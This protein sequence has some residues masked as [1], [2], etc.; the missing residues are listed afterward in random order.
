MRHT[1]KNNTGFTLVELIATLTLLTLLVLVAM[2]IMDR[3][4]S[5]STAKIDDAEIEMIET[6]ASAADNNGV[7]H[8]EPNLDQYKIRTLVE[9]GHLALDDEALYD[10]WVVGNDSGGY[11]YLGEREETPASDFTY[12]TVSSSYIGR[13]EETTS[14]PESLAGIAI[15]GY[16]GSSKE[17]VIPEEIDGQP[18][19]L[20]TTDALRENGFTAVYLPETVG[21]IEAGAFHSNNIS[22]FYTPDSIYRIDSNAFRSN[23]MTEAELPAN[24]EVM[25]HSTYRDNPIKHVDMGHMERLKSTAAYIF[26][27]TELES[28]VLPPNFEKVGDGMFQ[29]LNLSSI[30]LPDTLKEIGNNAFYGNDIKRVSIPDGVEEIGQHAFSHNGMRAV[31]LSPNTVTYGAYAFFTNELTEVE[32]PGNK[33]RELGGF[34]FHSNNLREVVLPEGLTTMGNQVF[35]NNSI[36]YVKLP[37]TLQSMGGY[38]FYTNNLGRVDGYRSGIDEGVAVWGGNPDVRFD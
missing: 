8:D 34:A 11:D 18:V 2:P 14:D 33:L 27:D 20:I 23:N 36:G 9:S 13:Y 26:F 15:T 4:L 32:F 10:H 17:I 3:V 22:T 6:A 16:T 7:R 28:V 37:S 35:R 25:G 31:K 1:Y 21:F 19:R 38:V 24:L 30:V 12:Q 29:D 5:D